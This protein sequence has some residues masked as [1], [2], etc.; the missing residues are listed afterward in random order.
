MKVVLAKQLCSSLPTTLLVAS[1][2]MHGNMKIVRPW[3]ESHWL[4]FWEGNLK[5]VLQNA[6]FP[7]KT[8]VSTLPSIGRLYLSVAFSIK[9][10][11]LSPLKSVLLPNL[12]HMVYRAT[13]KEKE[14]QAKF[15]DGTTNSYMPPMSLQPA[16]QLY[17]KFFYHP[18][19]KEFWPLRI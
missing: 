19:Y 11:T 3:E 16:K 5:R 12:C 14:G 6:D 4:L 17:R 15:T 1:G 2:K 10:D 9:V 13:P 18:V 7:A 8:Y